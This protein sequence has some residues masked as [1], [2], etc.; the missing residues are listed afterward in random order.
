MSRG[1]VVSPGMVIAVVLPQ[2]ASLA[3]AARRIP[4]RARRG[5]ASETGVSA[6]TGHGPRSPASGS[7]M[8]SDRKLDAAAFAVPAGPSRSSAGPNGP[9]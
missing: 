5:E 9:G 1:V 3:A 4:S 8:I 6:A 2:A 7:R